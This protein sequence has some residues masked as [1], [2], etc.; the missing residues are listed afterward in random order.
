[1]K[2]VVLTVAR[3]TVSP[4]IPPL[5]HGRTVPRWT[6]VVVSVGTGNVTPSATHETVSLTPTSVSLHASTAL[7]TL[8]KFHATSIDHARACT[9]EHRTRKPVL[10]WYDMALY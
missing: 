9:L 7:R 3:G 10:V 8:R 4:E 1:M 6:S 5:T 2:S